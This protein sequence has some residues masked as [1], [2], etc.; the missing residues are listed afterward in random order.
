MEP[1]SVSLM[2]KDGMTYAFISLE[3]TS[4]VVVF[5][6]TDV[7][8]PRFLDAVHNHPTKAPAESLFEDGKQGDIDPQG[9]FASAKM[10]TLFITGAVS[11][12]LTSYDIEM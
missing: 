9:L 12:T 2:T 7:R 10:N 3:R 4:M 11:N 5:N 8:A 6:I 1:E